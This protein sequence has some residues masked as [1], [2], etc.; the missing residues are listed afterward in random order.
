MKDR[1]IRE[2]KEKIE[3]DIRNGGNI[4]IVKSNLDKHNKCTG[5]IIHSGYILGDNFHNKN[6][7]VITE[8]GFENQETMNTI[9]NILQKTDNVFCCDEIA[10]KFM[11]RAIRVS[12][13]IDKSEVE[14]VSYY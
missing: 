6:T 14:M 8:L 7:M 9:D 2:K 11:N 5:F 13:T 3:N 4:M 12:K 10:V 1:I